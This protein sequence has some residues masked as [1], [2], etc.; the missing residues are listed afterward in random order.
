MKL[1]IPPDFNVKLNIEHALKLMNNALQN[2]FN[3]LP[4]ESRKV[5]PSE[6]PYGYIF[7]KE[8]IRQAIILKLAFVLSSLNA[9]KLLLGKGFVIEPGV[10]M[11][12]IDEATED[13]TF[14]SLAVIR[15][16]TELHERYLKNFWQKDIKKPDYSQEEIRE[17]I[18]KY[19]WEEIQKEKDPVKKEKLS[20]YKKFS[21]ER[22]SMYSKAVH[23]TSL[24]I[25]HIYREDPPGFHTKNNKKNSDSPNDENRYNAINPP[26]YW[27]LV[28][29]HYA[30]K[31][32]KASHLIKELDDYLFS[33]T[34]NNK[35]DER[36]LGLSK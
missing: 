29:Y 25:M 14:L 27:G 30:G 31:A 3:F 6:M 34:Q 23:S 32:L 1:D 21:R 12:T 20:H 35:M 18:R 8:G 19:I 10:L 17:E 36:V 26:I 5:Q 15:K 33:V 13:I 11:R 16:K 9:T 2:L 7:K 28:S 4:A 24:W 22:Y